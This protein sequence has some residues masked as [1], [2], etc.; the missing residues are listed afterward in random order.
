MQKNPHQGHDSN[1][2]MWLSS[3]FP[4]T[5]RA[6]FAPK[7]DVNSNNDKKRKYHPLLIDLEIKY[8]EVN[9]L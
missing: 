3:L 6:A 4:L 9:V 8:G 5:S 7:G 1:S 2:Q